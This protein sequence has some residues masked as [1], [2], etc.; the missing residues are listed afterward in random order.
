MWSSVS[1]TDSGM[2]GVAA[3]LSGRRAILNDLSPAAVHLAWNHTH[4]CDPAALMEGFALLERRLSRF[5]EELYSTEHSDGTPGLIH[6]ILWST[7]HKCPS[8]RKH[9]ALWDAIDH[10]TGRVG[11]TIS[12][13]LCSAE[14]TRKDLKSIDSRPA[15]I[16]YE[17]PDGKRHEKA[18]STKDIQRARKFKRTDIVAW[19]PDVPL[20]PD[21][22]M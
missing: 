18:A 9:F 16:A 15:W 3:A 14:I 1:T 13:P 2:T 12:C 21:R 4:P 5:F 8:C 10:K 7:E 22:E 17:L 6:W 20:G 11:T 19:T